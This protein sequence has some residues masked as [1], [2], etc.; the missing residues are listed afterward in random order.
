ML[1]RHDNVERTSRATIVTGVGEAVVEDA[2]ESVAEGSEDFGGGRP[3]FFG[4]RR[5][6]GSRDWT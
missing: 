6:L 2:D 3:W 1:P 5:R 4:G